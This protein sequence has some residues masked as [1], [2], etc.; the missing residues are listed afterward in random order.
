MMTMRVKVD[1]A[2]LLD[3]LRDNRNK[4]KTDF[5]ATWQGYLETSKKELRK[6]VRNV[7]KTKEGEGVTI[8]NLWPVP[9]SHVDDYDRIIGLIELSQDDQ[10]ELDDRD[11]ERYVLDKWDWKEQFLTSSRLY[12]P[13][14]LGK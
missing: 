13:L 4:H 8:P 12:S 6:A 2:K 7:D 11:Y 1:S 5:A 10:L 14:M 3:T 9:S